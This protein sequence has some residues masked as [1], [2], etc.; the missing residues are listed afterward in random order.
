MI[1]EEEFM[2][3]MMATASILGMFWP[4]LLVGYVAYKKFKKRKK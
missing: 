3:F 4:F 2:N 1:V